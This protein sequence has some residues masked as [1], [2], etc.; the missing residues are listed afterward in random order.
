MSAQALS[1]N[2]LM[3]LASS[4]W[5]PSYVQFRTAEWMTPQLATPLLPHDRCRVR[6]ARSQGASP[7]F[8][9]KTEL[10]TQLQLAGLSRR[11]GCLPRIDLPPIS[12][13][14]SSE[15]TPFA[16]ISDSA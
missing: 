15:L 2:S 12:V 9:P 3:L 10:A 4:R 14:C 7:D 8:L 1:A 6:V 13:F 5:R 16:S 11:F